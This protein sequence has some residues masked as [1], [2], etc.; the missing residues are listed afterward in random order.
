M[1]KNIISGVDRSRGSH[2]ALAW[3]IELAREVGATVHA[4]HV[5]SRIALW[6]LSAVQIDI[7]AYLEELKGFLNG[8]WTKPLRD[9]DIP[10][11][12][13]LVRGDP[14]TELL[15]IADSLDA[16]VIVAGRQKQAS[17]H[18][19]SIGGTAHKLINRA[20]RPVTLVPP[21]P[22]QQPRD[23]SGRF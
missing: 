4:V 10:F 3:S 6:G 22:D 8:V 7:D 19:H 20:N 16:F 13:Q 18:D 1:S 14:V 21:S 9:A 17:A 23:H 11:Y 15:R 5:E 2:D 12:T